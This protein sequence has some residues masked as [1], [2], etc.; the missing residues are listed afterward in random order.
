MITIFN[1]GGTF[2]KAYDELLGRLVVLNDNKII[3]TI[4]K[5]SFKSNP[6]PA[7]KGLIYKDSLDINKQD[8]KLLL[9]KIQKCKSKKIIIIHG[10]D[11]MNKTAKF[12]NKYI[13]NKVII[14]VGAMKPFSIEPI[15][16]TA[17]LMSAYGFLQTKNKTGVYISMNGLIEKYNKIKKNKTIG[18]FECR[19]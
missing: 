3:K 8:R 2:N 15:E 1:T 11:T 13:D 19:K 14:F 6:T 17:N 16:A 18:V 5:N 12:L 7:I 10:T 4:L 9:K